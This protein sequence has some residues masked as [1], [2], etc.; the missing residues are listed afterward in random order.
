LV[1]FIVNYTNFADSNAIVDAN[2]TLVDTILPYGN[3]NP[4]QY[5]MNAKEIELLRAQPE[6]RKCV[7]AAPQER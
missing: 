2:E 4:N 5:S 7:A 3:T 6:D 1:A